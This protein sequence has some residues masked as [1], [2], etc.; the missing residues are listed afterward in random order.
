MK[1][2]GAADQF[3][4]VIRQKVALAGHHGGGDGARVAL[5]LVVNAEGERVAGAVDG[6]EKAQRQRRRIGRRPD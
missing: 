4:G 5:Q 2:S 1:N 3:L 6:G